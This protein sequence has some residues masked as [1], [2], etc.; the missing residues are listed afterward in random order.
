M[1]GM[2]I[3]VRRM[4]RLCELLAPVAEVS[5][6]SPPFCV[7]RR[8]LGDSAAPEGDEVEEVEGERQ[9]SHRMV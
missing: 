5:S 7:G 9:Q 4:I 6:A 3:E 1:D 8:G 2:Q